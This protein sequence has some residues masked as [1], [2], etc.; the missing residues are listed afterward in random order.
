MRPGLSIGEFSQITHLSVKTL[1]RYHEAGLLP[2]AEVDPD[3]GYRY[4][5][6][7]QVP[8]AQLIRRFPE[9]GPSHEDCTPVVG[10]VGAARLP[11]DGLANG[12]SVL[13]VTLSAGSLGIS[14]HHAPLGSTS[15][16]YGALGTR[17]PAL[18]PAVAVPLSEP[19]LTGSG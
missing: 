12:G 7:T 3:T 14:V 2:P 8:T 19:L 15:L 11:A 6:L 18:A 9:L 5:A 13:T 16:W 1:R 10:G 4:Y 17:V